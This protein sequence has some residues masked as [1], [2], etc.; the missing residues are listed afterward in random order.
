LQ[1]ELEVRDSEVVESE[2]RSRSW[3]RWR[4]D[5]G[6]EESESSHGEDGSSLGVCRRRME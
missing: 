2:S 6:L 4:E 1:W 3:S 5:E